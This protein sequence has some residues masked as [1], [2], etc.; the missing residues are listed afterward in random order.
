MG[1]D[2]CK[3]HDSSGR[4]KALIELFLAIA[5]EQVG[6]SAMKASN[7]FT[8]LPLTALAIAGYSLSTLWFGRSMQI[9][10]MGFAYALWV[11]IGMM[12]S[13]LLGVFLFSELLT[14]AVMLGLMMVFSGI[15]VLN[16]SQEEAG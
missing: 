11:G 16:S 7:G 9:L 2:S 8:S 13:S 4:R 6:T 3:N 1:A 15:V 5:S 14:P 12:I 10:P